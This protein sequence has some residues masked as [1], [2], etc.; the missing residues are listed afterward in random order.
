MSAPRITP[1][2]AE[3]LARLNRL[4]PRRAAGWVYVGDIGSRGA[5]NRLRMKGLVEERVTRGPLGGER[6]WYRPVRP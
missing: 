3:V 1:H 4:S 6:L 5:L 2:Q